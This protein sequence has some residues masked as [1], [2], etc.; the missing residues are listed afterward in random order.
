ME[1]TR[2]IEKL[3]E[4]VMMDIPLNG[5][6]I[7][8]VEADGNNN[9]VAALTLQDTTGHR[10]EIRSGRYG[11]TINFVVPAVAPV[12]EEVPADE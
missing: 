8:K 11:S 4:M 2:T 6:T 12:G 3:D 5:I 10:L 9:A 1:Q 7:A